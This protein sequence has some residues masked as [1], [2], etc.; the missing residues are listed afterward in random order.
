[1]LSHVMFPFW[2]LSNLQFQDNEIDE[3]W[4][5]ISPRDLEES[6]EVREHLSDKISKELFW[7]SFLSHRLHFHFS[8]FS[9]WPKTPLLLLN[10][11]LTL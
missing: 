9:A 7:F 4:N 11:I 3:L 10:L 1:M 6:D 2:R 8:F 5:S